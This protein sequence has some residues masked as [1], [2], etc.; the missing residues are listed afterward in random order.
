[1]GG[2][3]PLAGIRWLVSY[4]AS[5][6]RGGG[7]V[8]KSS[9]QTTPNVRAYLLL[10]KMEGGT[11]PDDADL[12][13]GEQLCRLGAQI[14]CV[15]HKKS[16]ICTYFTSYFFVTTFSPSRRPHGPRTLGG[17]R[18]RRAAVRSVSSCCSLLHPSTQVLCCTHPS[19]IVLLNQTL[20]RRA[21]H[22]ATARLDVVSAPWGTALAL[23]A[24]SCVN[25]QHTRLSGS[26]APL[27]QTQPGF[28]RFHPPAAAASQPR[29]RPANP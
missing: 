5:E 22:R 25:A 7:S 10:V 27:P 19:S 6:S 12:R 23:L 28:A 8:Q 2:G 11:V 4:V 24:C 15:G 29:T 26:T 3:L 16:A 18:R 20:V 13:G 17:F 14:G 1:M 9:T 21:R